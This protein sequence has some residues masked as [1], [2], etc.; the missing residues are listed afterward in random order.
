MISRESLKGAEMWADSAEKAFD[1]LQSNPCGI[2]EHEAESRQHAFGT[3]EIAPKKKRGALLLF[4]S[5]FINPLILLLITVASVS[6]FLDPVNNTLSAGIILA[7]VVVSV[8]VTFYQEYT[9]RDEAEKLRK[10][11]RNT[12]TVV[13]DGAVREIPLK[14]LVPGDM[15]RLSAGDLVPADC[16]IISCKDF[17]VNQASL[18]GESLPVEKSPSPSLP[19]SQ[20]QKMENA[21]FFGSS[22]VSGSAE[23][24]VIRTGLYTQFGELARRLSQSAPETA[25]DRGIRDY[26]GLMVKFVIVLVVMIF[27]IN[28][29]C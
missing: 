9:A 15:V 29:V 27:I 20:V 10:M 16:R 3:N 6:Y 24:L 23:A 5:Y 21:A 12:A 14:F 8:S 4:L 7:M 22:V 17:F 13:R 25:F 26:S 2:S 11:I 18:T 28:A 1:I 19:K